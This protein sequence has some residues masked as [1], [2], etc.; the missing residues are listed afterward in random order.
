M[1]FIGNQPALSYTSFAKQDFTTSAT[2]TYTLDNPVANANE[3]ALF[4]NFVRQEPTTA[5]SASGTTLT[6]TE[7]TSS[8]DDMYCVYLGKAVQTVTPASGSVTNAMLGETIT[9]ANGGTGLTS[10]FANG[11]TMTDQ[12]RLTADIS[13]TDGDLTSNLERVDDSEFGKI[14]TGMTESSGIFSFPSTGLYLIHATMESLSQT[15][16]VVMQINITGNN[17][18]YNNEGTITQGDGDSHGTNFSSGSKIVFFNVT[19]TSTH[20]VKFTIQSS[21]S[22]TVR[23]NTN[24]NETCFTFIR[25]GDSV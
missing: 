21:A 14:G 8:S 11:I 1:L 25:L 15:D 16:A 20:K 17:S 4:L 19:D 22:S 5:Y 2:T 13:N 24:L 3:L 18:T 10:G 23:G 12:F 6:L 9:V 7:A